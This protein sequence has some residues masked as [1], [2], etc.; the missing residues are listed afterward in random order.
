MQAMAVVYMLNMTKYIAPLKSLHY[1][2]LSLYTEVYKYIQI[3]LSL[4]TDL[5]ENSFVD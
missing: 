5:N 3:V 1:P 2:E 4:N